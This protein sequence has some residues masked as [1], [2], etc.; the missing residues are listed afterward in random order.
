MSNEEHERDQ[1]S[2]VD[3][4]IDAALAIAEYACEDCGRGDHP[5]LDEKSKKWKHGKRHCRAQHAWF[6]LRRAEDKRVQAWFDRKYGGQWLSYYA[7]KGPIGP[8]CH[9]CGRPAQ[10]RCDFNCWGSICEFDACIDCAEKWDG[11]HADAIPRAKDRRQDR[12]KAA[13]R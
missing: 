9:C 4:R 2:Y 10:R 3:G 1:L 13:T 7:L 8:E 12:M 11:V 6:E 5:V